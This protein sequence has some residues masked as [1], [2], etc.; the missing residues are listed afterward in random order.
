MMLT[1]ELLKT[2]IF[3]EEDVIHVK[4]VI[5]KDYSRVLSA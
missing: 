1:I 4:I 5:Y 3:K 2:S